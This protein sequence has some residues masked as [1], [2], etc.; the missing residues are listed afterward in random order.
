MSFTLN[1]AN[2]LED[3]AGWARAMGASQL[4]FATS[5]ALN[6]VAQDAADEVTKE[7][8]RRLDRPTSFTMR[9]WS[10]GRSTK[11]SLTAAVFAKDAQARYLRWQVAGGSR[12]PNRQ[13]QRLPS[14]IK[15]DQFGN[16]PRGEI[17]R[18]VS[19]AKA[20]KRL[21]KARGARLGISSK[22]DLFYGDP[23]NGMP[24]GIYKRVVQGADHKLVPLVVFPRVNAQYTARLPLERIVRDT[25]RA[26]FEARFATA[27]ATAMRTAR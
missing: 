12:A 14:A 17:A 8:G 26:R 6:A 7:T 11:A 15:L 1:L 9:A 23:G 24:P 21:T 19:L 5:L 18:M 22:L 3:V 2:Q 13:A 4:P 25:V 16:L 20:G 27:W 10:V